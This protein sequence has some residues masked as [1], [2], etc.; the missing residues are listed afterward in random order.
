MEIL[1]STLSDLA[2][3]TGVPALY[4]LA[5]AGDS[6]FYIAI[7][8]AVGGLALSAIEG[9]KKSPS[10]VLQIARH[11]LSIVLSSAQ[12]F[13]LFDE[14]DGDVGAGLVAIPFFFVVCVQPTGYL[15]EYSRHARLLS[16]GLTLASLMTAMIHYTVEGNPPSPTPASSYDT[17]LLRGLSVVNLAFA[18]S[19]DSDSLASTAARG[20]VYVALCLVPAAVK[21]LLSGPHP[22][23]ILAAYGA[24]LAW[25]AHYAA[26][27]VR[28]AV[29]SQRSLRDPQRA[30]MLM[31]A[32]ALT[33][34]FAERRGEPAHA[35]I[36][37]LTVVGLGVLLSLLSYLKRDTRSE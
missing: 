3:G 11:F 10:S 8:G 2:T 7:G 18:T 31:V 14:Q 20:A 23:V 13:R 30:L 29:S 5:T 25:S 21:G 19:S 1:A 16:S 6:A 37:L 24:A 33:V 26:C 9:Y 15:P 4:S 12:L 36:A 27:C 32:P 17:G 34:G 22:M 28:L 35:S